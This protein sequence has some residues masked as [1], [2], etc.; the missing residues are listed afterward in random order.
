[1]NVKLRTNTIK[2]SVFIV[3]YQVKAA[4]IRQRRKFVFFVP[5]RTLLPSNREIR[6]ER[7]EEEEQGERRPRE[8]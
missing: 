2:L 3:S 4:F 5:F 8:L 6:E 1:V 7:E